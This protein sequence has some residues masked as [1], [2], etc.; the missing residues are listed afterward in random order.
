MGTGWQTYLKNKFCRNIVHK[1]F[2]E[3]PKTKIVQVK[4]FPFTMQAR[5]NIFDILW[6]AKF[7]MGLF[8]NCLWE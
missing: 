4:P 7:S 2:L 6:P 5:V 3:A 8:L 1:I